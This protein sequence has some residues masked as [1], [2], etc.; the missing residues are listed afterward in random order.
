MAPA[1]GGRTV[2][3][4]TVVGLISVVCTVGA[5]TCSVT[6]SSTFS[7]LCTATSL[8]MTGCTSV[9]YISTWIGE[10][11]QRGELKEK[12]KT[13]RGKGVWQYLL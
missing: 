4:R 8:W 11:R 5:T 13:R 9:Q 12:R 1:W 10:E 6:C 3:G 7:T 2:V